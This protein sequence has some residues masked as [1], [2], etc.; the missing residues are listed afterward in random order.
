[1]KRSLL[2]AVFVLL[3][4]QTHA[5][6]YSNDWIDFTNNQ[7]YSKQQYYKFRVSKEGIYRIP[8]DSLIKA[9]IPVK[10]STNPA[11]TIDVRSLQLFCRGQE[12]Y[13]AVEGASNGVFNSGGYIEFYGQPNDGWF[14]E[15]M[16]IT[17]Q[18]QTNPRHSLVTDTA[19]YFLTW[20]TSLNNRRLSN[21]NDIAFG[22]YSLS[23]SFLKESFAQFVTYYYDGEHDGVDS[24]DPE[25]I[26]GEGY[27]GIAFD[28]GSP[29]YTASLEARNIASSSSPARL[30][31][32]VLGL[33][34]DKNWPGSDHRLIISINGQNYFDT[35]YN[36]YRMNKISFNIPLGQ[37]TNSTSIR[38]ANS[39]PGLAP[40][41]DRQAVSWVSLQYPHTL[42][43]AGETA[44]LQT[45]FISDE[46]QGKSRLSITNFPLSG[47]VVLYDITNHRKIQVVNSGGT[48]NALVPNSPVFGTGKKCILSSEFSTISAAGIK[49]VRE[50]GDPDG[51]ARF[52]DFRNN[53]Y[54]KDYVILTHS[55]L[56]DGAQ[57][58]KAY[59][60]L[61][62]GFKVGIVDVEE[63]YDQFGYGIRKHPLS[64]RGFAEYILNQWD[65]KPSYL[66]LIGKSI[67]LSEYR[68]APGQG[69][70]NNA[71]AAKNLV[72]TMG[73]PPSD[74]MLTARIG[75]FSKIEPAIPTGRLSATSVK[76]IEDYLK[77]VKDYESA[78]IEE[79]MKK[80]IHLGGGNNDSQQ[81]LFRGYLDT[82]SSLAEDSL[83]GGHVTSFYKDATAP[84]INQSDSLKKLVEDGVSVITFFG[85]SSPTIFDYSLDDPKNYD[86]TQGHYSFFI[87]NGCYAGN[88]HTEDGSS[89]EN[90]VLI[91][92]K[93]SIGF[94]ASSYLSTIGPLHEFTTQFYSLMSNK[95]YG[96][97]AGKIIRAT[98]DSIQRRLDPLNPLIYYKEILFE[99][100]LEGDPAVVINSSPAPDL[101]ITQPDIF[102]TPS[103]VT[104]D[105]ST[106]TMNVVMTN[107]GKTF[108]DSFFVQVKRTF[109]D[110][111]DS[112]M[113]LLVKP[114]YYKDTLRIPLPVDLTK[115]P[116]LNLFEVFLDASEKI[117]EVS[118]RNTSGEMNNRATAQLLIQST[119]LIPVSPAKYAIV[120][121]KTVTLKAV[122]GNI[123]AG[124]RSYTMEFDT[125]DLFNSPFLKTTTVT[126]VG[127]VVS[128]TPPVSLTDSTVYYWRSSLTGSGVWKESS[129]IYIPG[130]KGWSQAHFF[131]F[132]DDKY[133]NIQYSRPSRRFEFVDE[134]KSIRAKTFIRDGNGQPSAAEFSFYL[135]NAP[136]RQGVYISRGFVVAVYDPDSAKFWRSDMGSYGHV[137]SA[138]VSTPGFDFQIN[139]GDTTQ[140]GYLQRFLDKVPQGH[141]VLM[142]SIN[143][144]FYSQ[145]SSSLKGAFNRL[146]STLI[147][148]APG[149]TTVRDTL[150]YIL[151]TRKGSGPAHELVGTRMY[152]SIT[153][154]D[155]ILL[156]WTSGFITSEKIGPARSWDQLRWRQ[157]S[158][159][160]PTN[161][162]LKV[163]VIGVTP[164]GAE[165][166]LIGGIP[167]DSST[168]PLAS[169]I[170]ASAYPYLKLRYWT[171]DVSTRTPSQLAKWQIYY[172]GVPEA[173]L[174]PARN[175]TF[176]RDTLQEGEIL[177]FSSAIENISD[178]DMDSLHIR[179]WVYDR[180]RVQHTLYN[181]KRKPLLA[182][183]KSPN[184]TIIFAAQFDTRAFAGNNS[185]WIDVNPS[186]MQPEQYHFNNISN[187]PFFVKKDVENPL[188]DVTFDGVHILDGDI[189][190]AKPK[191]TIRMKDENQFLALNDTS[192]FRVWLLPP[193]TA[194]IE[195]NRLY[196]KNGDINNATALRFSAGA[197]PKNTAEVEYSPVLQ[198]G[199]Y[200]LMV[201]GV[202]ASKNE[203][204]RRNYKISFEVINKSTITGVFN[205]P[206]PFSTSTRF[207]FTLTGSE[208]PTQFKIQILTV[209]GKVVREI[210]LH[211]L[212]P[213][214]VGRNVTEYAWDGK[215]EFG[216]QLAN[217]LY[218]YR[219][220]TAINGAA[221]EKRGTSADK[222]F[223]K[224]YG[225]MYLMR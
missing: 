197:P 85:H 28:L 90:Y 84:Q 145:F 199:I 126:Q 170:D 139:Y 89:G 62:N 2:Y 63:V 91:P 194:D 136:Q 44:P 10:T 217:G 75:G 108:A 115:G 120:P 117:S 132:K 167:V 87:A 78:P 215:D 223:V 202:D 22:S 14:D 23:T 154:N 4:I 176:Y 149:D 213:I 107:T 135:D 188:V 175:F 112:T 24:S 18:S 21:E 209:T 225:K 88:I 172:E 219:V 121:E 8:A 92:E 165:F 30:T 216:D 100:T 210:M 15:K 220:I 50:S 103:S 207:V 171:E 57:Q 73:F 29:S 93:G 118:P 97:P 168:V 11:N 212:G 142:Y 177:K 138:F 162:T 113:N 187:L 60:E 144:P 184:D 106:F 131:Q 173:T 19:T 221:I 61:K 6:N 3:G 65:V 39:W 140:H 12:Q 79:W 148:N 67:I 158:I 134:I 164:G 68:I 109:G 35:L 94:L 203:S 128:W 95:M 96:Q 13:I 72:P 80:L 101:K 69:V 151:F 53:N 110:N 123:F 56:M 196:F 42:S 99:M 119:D 133:K 55:S 59:R 125:T 1:M 48:L 191:I 58:Y 25:Y 155:S 17:P 116:G 32:T 9:G 51:Y 7:E 169:R 27:G 41:A 152:E 74:N 159:E 180:N 183:G 198:D 146:G 102:F 150:P 185:F 205:Y 192:M 160:S 83:F 166:T 71:M 208:V 33:S 49:P 64:I 181:S 218:I 178:Y 186:G 190:S 76:H 111:S 66:L 47:P 222:F 224:D 52:V 5:Q 193:G 147:G 46:V 81:R 179:V 129:F 104:T 26:A 163:D 124:T 105:M 43:F 54:D 156:K 143:Q 189:V 206:N 77:K 45:L 204:G 114:V 31:T 70:M 98:V 161:D 127:G 36:G 195:K 141:Y 174:N 34:D 201:E 157:R 40:A 153:L 122:T 82:Y 137:N 16:Y 130:K 20:N 200:T 86:V 211:E 214:R 37:L 38:Y 182:S